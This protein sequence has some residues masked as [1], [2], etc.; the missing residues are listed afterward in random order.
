MSRKL[1]PVPCGDLCTGL[2]SILP[3]PAR[4]PQTPATRR[5]RIIQ[6]APVLLMSVFL[7][8]LRR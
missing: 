3:L 4:S 1:G 8:P 2:P 6:T 7:I 5:C